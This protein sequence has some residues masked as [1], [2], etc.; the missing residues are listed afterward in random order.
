MQV[1][2]NTCSYMHKYARTRINNKIYLLEISKRRIKLED[3]KE[4]LKTEMCAYVFIWYIHVNGIS[5]KRLV[6]GNKQTV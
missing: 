6:E 3:F 2:T 1:V 4:K 5:R